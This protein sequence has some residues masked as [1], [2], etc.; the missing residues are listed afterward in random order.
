V[1]TLRVENGTDGIAQIVIDLPGRPMNVITP[2][3]QADLA[4]A[5]DR[6]LQDGA[7]RGVILGSGKPGS[8]IAGA[9]INQMLAMFDRGVDARQGA[10]LS[11]GLSDLLRRLEKGGKPVAC[12]INGVALGGGFEVA[13]ACHYRVLADDAGV[14][15][16]E[17]GLG[18]LPGAGGTQ[19]LPR[20][21]GIEKAEPLLLT[22]RTV[23]AAEA[24]KLGIVD[25]VAPA[26]EVV[27]RARAWLL[28]SP[29]T[30]QPWDEKGFKVPGGAGPGAAHAE[31]SFTAGTALAAQSTQRNYPAP[32]AILS[33]LY[34]GT[35]VSIDTGLRIESKYFGQL[36][37][38]P[39]AR[40]MMRTLFVNKNAADKLAAR[41]LGIA[42]SKV[43]RLGVL[44]AGMMGAGI[45][46]VAA[47]A[48]IEV[49]LLDSI[50]SMRCSGV[51][52]RPATTPT[53]RAAIWWS[54][55]C[56]N[57]AASRRK[58]P[59]APA[60]CC[61]PARSSPATRRRCRSAS[62]QRRIRGRRISSACTSSRRWTRCRW[63][64]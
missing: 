54:R 31:R 19:R 45:A 53:S 24:L 42:K 61:A 12:A 4:A 18:L 22:G 49:V 1:Q 62:W 50:R 5:L 37:A 20:L 9:D 59:A 57:R 52:G 28:A 30:T 64:K 40:N 33:C 47:K 15:L 25:A 36:L 11:R 3:L 10:Q 17:V 41:P 27:E 21:I 34:E 14:G 29:K 38:G 23:K 43:A 51:S 63:W 46:Y 58:S 48:G 7:V 2:E 39:V 6:V 32:L 16:P 8:F 44:G 26:A 60:R 35:Q 56:S 55:R 13:L